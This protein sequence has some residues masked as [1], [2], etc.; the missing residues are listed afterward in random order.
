[1]SPRIQ[2]KPADTADPLTTMSS[3]VQT[4]YLTKVLLSWFER[5]RS[6][7]IMRIAGDEEADLM[8]PTPFVSETKRDQ[9]T[10]DWVANKVARWRSSNVE[11]RG[12]RRG[13]T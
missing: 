5:V 8:T 4:A 2:F 11:G 1:M 3:K 12:H 6:V 9:A 7:L 10:Y 13:A